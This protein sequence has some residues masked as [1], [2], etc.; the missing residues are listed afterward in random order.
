[1]EVALLSE[2]Q[3]YFKKRA[4]VEVEYS[5]NLE[6]LAKQIS[7]KHKAEKQKYVDMIFMKILLIQKFIFRRESWSLFWPQLYSWWQQLINETKNEARYRSV[8]ADIYTHHAATK[9]ASQAE[10]LQRISKRVSDQF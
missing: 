5:R 2:I 7:G 3:D 6:K 8:V 10:E 9:M 4:E 1:M